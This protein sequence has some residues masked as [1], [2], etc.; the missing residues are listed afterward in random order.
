MSETLFLAA[1]LLL[2][3]G[4]MGLYFYSRIMYVDRKLNYIE[5]ILIDLR[6]KQEMERKFSPL[7][8]IPVKAPEPLETDDSEDIKDEKEFY[9][10]VIES[11]AATAP[12]ATAHTALAEEDDAPQEATNEVVPDYDSMSRDEVAAIAEKKSIRITKRM[13]KSTII[14]LLRESEKNA[15]ATVE[16]GKDGGAPLSMETDSAIKPAESS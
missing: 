7:A 10:S 13:N 15:S 8:P 14:N 3:I 2:L 12:A 5:S 4:A 11:S 9:N 1:V 16:V 6:M